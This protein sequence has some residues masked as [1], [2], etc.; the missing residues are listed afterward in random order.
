MRATHGT[1]ALNI[2]NTHTHTTKVSNVSGVQT[3]VHAAYP[4]RAPLQKH[5]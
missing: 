3:V 4:V 2:T 5:T 1:V